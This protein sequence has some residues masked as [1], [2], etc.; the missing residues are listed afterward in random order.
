LGER[1]LKEVW[2]C[3]GKRLKME[4]IAIENEKNRLRLQITGEGHTFCNILKKELWNDNS[5]EIAG[6]SIGH[7]LTGEPVFTVEVNKGDAKKALIDAVARLKKT[8]KEF[9]DKSKVI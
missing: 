7:S 5:V 9:K 3:S 6:Y 8:A 1:F 4:I 2:G